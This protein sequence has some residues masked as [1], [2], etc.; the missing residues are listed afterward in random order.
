MS[1]FTRLSMLISEFTDYQ[2]LVMDSKLLLSVCADSVGTIQA[3]ISD[4]SQSSPSKPSV[5]LTTL[6][7]S[8]LTTL[9]AQTT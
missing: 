9:R 1:S 7:R 2:L 5:Q 6:E 3:I 4:L 8:V